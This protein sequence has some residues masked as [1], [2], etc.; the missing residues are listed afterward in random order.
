ME[1]LLAPALGEGKHR[2]RGEQEEHSG[3]ERGAEAVARVVPAEPDTCRVEAAVVTSLVLV[4][5]A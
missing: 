2:R 5:R 1:V 4:S 3:V